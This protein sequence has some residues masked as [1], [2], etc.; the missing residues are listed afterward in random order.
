MWIKCSLHRIFTEKK[1][2]EMAKTA[3]VLLAEGAEEMETVITVDVLRRAEID[4]T[5]AGLTGPDTVKCSRGVFVKPDVALSEA[6]SKQYDIII[7]PG[8]L[9][10]AQAIADV[11]IVSHVIAMSCNFSFFQVCQLR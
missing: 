2:I 6:A 8:G 10:G 7:L 5:V 11:N 4:V 1:I 9:K 3:L